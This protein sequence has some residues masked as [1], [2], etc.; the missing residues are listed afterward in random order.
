[1]KPRSEWPELLKV[2]G[3]WGAAFGN[4]YL[5]AR[6]Q[7]E[8]AEKYLEERVKSYQKTVDDYLEAAYGSRAARRAPTHQPGAYI[9]DPVDGV[10]LEEFTK[11]IPD[12]Q[13]VPPRI[14]IVEYDHSPDARGY[15]IIP[16]Q[17]DFRQVIKRLG[18][19]LAQPENHIL[20]ESG[21]YEPYLDHPRQYTDVEAQIANE[22]TRLPQYHAR[23][24][25]GT[26]EVEI[27]TLKPDAHADYQRAERI[28]ERSRQVYG[29]DRAE[30]ERGIAERLQGQL[31]S[32]TAAPSPGD[33]KV[34]P[35][36]GEPSEW[37]S[38][39]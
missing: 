9:F 22:L 20:T 36:R 3:E 4:P 28:R 27:R 24:K 16:H 2:L 6:E 10:S 5:L 38:V 21:Q 11:S 13:I 8:E 1:L 34:K 15:S 30:V 25:L 29:R 31:R 37:E 32:A 19:L 7:G 26:D 14:E 35:G 33:G 23:C 12:S 17:E 18:D 39:N